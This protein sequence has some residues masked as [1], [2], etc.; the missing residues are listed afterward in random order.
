MSDVYKKIN[1]R[2]TTEKDKLAIIILQSLEVRFKFYRR[3]TSLWAG[4]KQ[5]FELKTYRIFY[6]PKFLN[7][8]L[9]KVKYKRQ[10]FFN[11]L[12]TQFILKLQQSD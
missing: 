5:I 10:I 4:L 11:D 2:Q 8:L 1:L 3:Q 7:E 9:L 12:C 6:S